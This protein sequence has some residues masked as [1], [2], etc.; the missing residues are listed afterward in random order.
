MTG[1]QRRFNAVAKLYSLGGQAPYFSVQ[2][3]ERN[4]RRRGDNQIEACGCLHDEVVAHFPEVAAVV[5]V[6]LADEHG[7]PMHAVAN[8]VY[9]AGLS[10]RYMPDVEN[11]CGRYEIEEDGAGHTWAPTMLANHLRI[12]VNEARG[13]RAV[14]AT[15]P[16]A[17]ASEVLAAYITDHLAPAWQAE[18]DA[19]MVVLNGGAS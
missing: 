17:T 19:A 7:V 1:E 10:G 2:G 13:L 4:L 11:S 6:H 18:A 16:G 9:W 8:G 5:R 14:S 12:T 15:Y 3:E